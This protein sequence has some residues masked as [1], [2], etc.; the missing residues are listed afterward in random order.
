MLRYDWFDVWICIWWWQLRES[1]S[2]LFIFL[3]FGR[4]YCR[5]WSHS[6]VRCRWLLFAWKHWPDYI[7][8][9]Q[10]IFTSLFTHAH[11]YEYIYAHI[12]EHTSI[13]T[14][15]STGITYTH[16][17][18][19]TARISNIFLTHDAMQDSFSSEI[20][21]NYSKL[22]VIMN[23]WNTIIGHWRTDSFADAN[24]PFIMCL[25]ERAFLIFIP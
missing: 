4:T 18:L 1:R 20:Q 19:S 21:W 13:F 14:H 7:R 5:T 8:R 24:R 22:M 23:T 9:Y 6:I 17:Y 25:F 16:T 12:H 2:S 10:N 11:T 15:S 3:G